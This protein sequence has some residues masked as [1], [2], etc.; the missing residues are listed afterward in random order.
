ME[1][2]RHAEPDPLF[3]QHAPREG[4]RPL[5][6][7]FALFA[8]D[9]LVEIDRRA[10]R[11]AGILEDLFHVLLVREVDDP[12]RDLRLPGPQRSRPAVMPVDD[13]ISLRMRPL[14]DD[15]LALVIMLGHL[16]RVHILLLIRG[17]DLVIRTDLRRAE[18]ILRVGMKIVAARLADQQAAQ[19]PGLDRETD[20]LAVLHFLRQVFIKKRF[21][22]CHGPSLLRR[23]AFYVSL[24]CGR[25]LRTARGPG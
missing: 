10:L 8:E 6:R 12:D 7:R 23:S 24:S 13:P 22:S 5:Q 1:Q 11:V 14:D 25:G 9:H 4:Q 16:Q 18:L 19:D 2:R 15:R 3:I 20:A 17:N 21:A